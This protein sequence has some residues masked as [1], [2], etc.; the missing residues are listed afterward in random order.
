MRLAPALAVRQTEHLGTAFLEQTIDGVVE[1]RQADG[2]AG[3]EHDALATRSRPREPGP[4]R[5]ARLDDRLGCDLD[6]TEAGLVID[7]HTGALRDQIEDVVDPERAGDPRQP[8]QLV[9]VP[10][11]QHEALPRTLSSGCVETPATPATSSSQSAAASASRSC[12]RGD[13]RSSSEGRRSTCRSITSMQS[14][15]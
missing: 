12:G 13:Q 15:C 2:M 5:L 3:G 1:Q 4:H 9:R 7:R 10:V 6:R 11:D 8:E 14:R